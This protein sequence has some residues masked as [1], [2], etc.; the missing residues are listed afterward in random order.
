MANGKIKILLVEDDSFLRE[1]IFNKLAKEGFDVT[2]ADDGEKAL[3]FAL[4]GGFDIILLD[5]IIPIVNGFEVLE[6]IKSQEDENISKVP[7]I[8]LSNLGEEDDVKKAIDLGASNYLVKAHFTTDEVI[9]KIKKEL[10][11]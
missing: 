3:G 5:L 10:R 4:A 7:V 8:I 2:E 1:I 9:E 6:K 11:Q